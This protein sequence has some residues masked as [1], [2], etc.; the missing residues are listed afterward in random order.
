MKAY[1]LRRPQPGF[2]HSHGWKDVRYTP[3]NWK[4]SYLIWCALSRGDTQ[5]EIYHK[6]IKG[7]RRIINYTVDF[8]S[9]E[10]TENVSFANKHRLVFGHVDL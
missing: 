10:V 4:N 6:S 8:V 1:F 5:V 9:N 3:F 7:N 2:L